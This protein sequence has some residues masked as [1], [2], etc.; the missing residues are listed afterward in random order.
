MVIY[1]FFHNYIFTD[2]ISFLHRYIDDILLVPI[3]GTIILYFH[4]RF[5]ENSYTLP[6]SHIVTIVVANAIVFELILPLFSEQYTRDLI[7]I[8]AYTIGAMFFHLEMNK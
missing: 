4:K 3:V 2:S 5:R 1:V 6:I 7:D 8:A